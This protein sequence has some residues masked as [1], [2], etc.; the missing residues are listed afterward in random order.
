M[1]LA[2]VENFKI[3]FDPTYLDRMDP[4]ETDSLAYLCQSSEPWRITS[5]DGIVFK[6][7]GRLARG[8]QGI[9]LEE[10]L[11]QTGLV[12]ELKWQYTK[13]FRL[14]YTRQGEHDS[15]TGRGMK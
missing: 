8:E 11:Q 6:I 4:G 1:P 15:I 5:G 7:L 3:K 13:E 9:S 10:I 2:Q 14:K 12:R